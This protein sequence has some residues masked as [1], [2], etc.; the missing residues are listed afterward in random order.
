MMPMS[1]A[2]DMSFHRSLAGRMLGFG[3]FVVESAGKD[4]VL[5]TIDH[6]PYPEQLYLVVCGRIFKDPTDQEQQ[7]DPGGPLL[8]DDDGLLE[9]QP[10]DPYNGST[11]PYGFNA[12]DDPDD[13]L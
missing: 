9:G 5:H 7:F 13:E 8:D 6:V 4:Q 2:T 11:G 10:N 12:P 1:K 3:D